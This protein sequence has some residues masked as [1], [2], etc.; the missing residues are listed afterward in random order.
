MALT[1]SRRLAAVLSASLCLA[2]S[3]SLGAAAQ[4]DTQ[5]QFRTAPPKPVDTSENPKPGQPSQAPLPVPQTPAGG[6]RMASCGIIAPPDAPA[7]PKDVTTESWVVADLD[8]GQILGAKDPHARQRPASLIKVLLSLVVLDELGDKMDKVITGTAEDASQDGTRVGIGPGGQY[9]VRQL[10]Y[11]LLMR[12]GNDCAHALAMQMGGIEQTVAKMNAKAKSLDALDTQTATPS[13][14]DGPGMMTS[15]FDLAVFFREAMRNPEFAKAVAT[16]QLDM[17]GYGD[18][19]G[20]KVN[21][22]NGLLGKYQG[23]LGGKTGFTDDARH[24]YLG[25]AEQGGHRLEVVLMRGEQSPVR[26]SDQGGHLFTWAFG[27]YTKGRI[28]PVGQLTTVKPPPPPPT[29]ENGSSS[30]EGHAS[31]TAAGGH[32]DNNKGLLPTVAMSVSAVAVLGFVIWRIRRRY[33]RPA[34]SPHDPQGPGDEELTVRIPRV[35]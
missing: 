14:L 25:G 24:T 8:T 34:V 29:A 13:G 28:D 32:P 6:P 15:A 19:P 3:T 31:T 21:N 27:L 4:P 35:R 23:F 5:C 16:K 9:T 10:F 18:K 11:T 30:S 20:F 1:Y 7:P 26:M 12:S 22:D 33:A 2:L 17:P